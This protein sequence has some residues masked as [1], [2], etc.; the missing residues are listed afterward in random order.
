[1]GLFRKTKFDLGEWQQIHQIIWTAIHTPNLLRE[2]NA[3]E[4]GLWKSLALLEK[5]PSK[6]S[7]Q[8]WHELIRTI[9]IVEEKGNQFTPSVNK[10]Y[11]E[12][13]IKS[14]SAIKKA[15][16]KVYGNV[17]ENPS[18][19]EEIMDSTLSF[20]LTDKEKKDKR[21]LEE[22]A[23]KERL[24]KI[25]ERIK[26]RQKRIK[27]DSKK[28]TGDDLL[29]RG[30]WFYRDL[31][32][33]ADLGAERIIALHNLYMSKFETDYPMYTAVYKDVNKFARHL[34]SLQMDLN[35][36][37]Y[38]DNQ[39]SKLGKAFRKKV[40]TYVKQPSGDSMRE[41]VKGFSKFYSTITTNWESAPGEDVYKGISDE[42]LIKL[43]RKR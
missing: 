30:L 41:M 17:V 20:E 33:V 35:K 26:D 23:E 42:D 16:L 36:Y 28:V 18:T 19:I 6:V 32:T 5:T 9:L 11:M 15:L 29:C 21:E 43:G 10:S 40:D 25:E 2:S 38:P 22:K 27:A 8:D 39:V 31:H 34:S 37:P 4:K 24:K 12:G 13:A 14:S 3:N 1:M 7:K